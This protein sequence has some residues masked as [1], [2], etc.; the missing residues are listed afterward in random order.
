MI[1]NAEAFKLSNITFMSGG[2][3]NCRICLE[4]TREFYAHSRILAGPRFDI[5]YRSGFTT[6]ML[7][8]QLEQ[9][10]AELA[11]LK[12]RKLKLLDGIKEGRVNRKRFLNM[13]NNKRA[14]T[15]AKH[16]SQACIRKEQIAKE[17]PQVQCDL[18]AFKKLGRKYNIKDGH[19]SLHT[20]F[21]YVESSNMSNLFLSTP[22]DI[23]HTLR[24]GLLECSLRYT[25]VILSHY[26]QTIDRKYRH[27]LGILDNRV[28]KFQGSHPYIPSSDTTPRFPTMHKGISYIFRVK[29][30][31]AVQDKAS[32]ATMSGGNIDAS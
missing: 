5:E 23:L 30:R 15:L 2:I 31:K 12:I 9:K 17:I 26:T 29:G 6:N 4:E 16:L 14:E 18:D 24:K 27:S 8:V 25:I 11:K 13:G 10:W 20:L 7:C 19:N 21:H 3:R 1:D 32:G 22:P 28:Q